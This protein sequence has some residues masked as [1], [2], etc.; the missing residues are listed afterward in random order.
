MRASFDTWTSLFLL[1]AAF[2]LFLSGIIFSGR[3]QRN[4]MLGG[5]VLGYTFMLTYYVLYWTNYQLQLP[6]MIAAATGFTYLIGPLFYFF[7]RSNKSETY[8]RRLHLIP[9]LLVMVYHI[10]P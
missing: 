2:G 7:L 5:I 6:W 1:N 9:F 10:M 3:T 8:F 4:Y